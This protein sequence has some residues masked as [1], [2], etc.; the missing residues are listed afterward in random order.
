[1]VCM[2]TDHQKYGLQVKSADDKLAQGHRGW[3][4]LSMTVELL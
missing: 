1:M 3:H 4:G 2:Q